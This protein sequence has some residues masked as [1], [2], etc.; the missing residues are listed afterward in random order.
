MTMQND[1]GT[2]SF[3]AFLES[4]GVEP[5]AIRAIEC[6]EAEDDYRAGVKALSESDESFLRF[7][8]GRSPLFA[9]FFFARRAYETRSEW[10]RRGIPFFVWRDT[11]T[12]LGIW[13]RVCRR[14][15][16][17]LG[18]SETAWLLNH[19]NLRI[20]RLG[21]LQFAPDSVSVGQTV[22]F[23]AAGGP[24][25]S[26]G[27]RFYWVHIPE[28]ESLTREFCDDSFALAAEFFGGR[29]VFACDSW[30]LS[31]VADAVST[32]FQSGGVCETV[33]DSF[34]LCGF[35]EC[36]KISVRKDRRS[37]VLFRRYFPATGGKEIS[38][39]K[40]SIGHGTRNF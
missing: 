20:F 4:A 34:F 8:E 17:I 23:S 9:L 26:L 38:F 29:M 11:F 40:G 19:L 35:P 28:G 39:G 33:Q 32:G 7:A 14:E 2:V 6:F 18:I 1:Y 36:G 12:D 27:E 24:S 25:L 31:P 15:R 37:R 5:E 21:R 22:E 10:Q 30:I 13:Q 16:G 3:R